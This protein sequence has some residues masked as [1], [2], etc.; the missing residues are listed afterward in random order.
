M[1]R[2]VVGLML[3]A[4]PLAVRGENAGA[5]VLVN[6][7]APD[8]ADFHTLLEP[9]LVHFGVP[10]ETLDLAEHRLDNRLADSSLV[11][12]GHCGLDPARRFLNEAA[13]QVLADAVRRGTGLVSFDGLVATWT[14]RQAQPV[15]RFSQEIFGWRFTPAQE[16]GAI[17]IAGGHWITA[18]R[19][20]PRRLQLKATMLVPGLAPGADE[21]QVLAGAAGKPLL[22]AAPFGSGRAV[23]FS[24]YDW[25]QPAVKGKL[26]GLD[27]LVWRSLVWAARKP[28]VM[29]GMPRYLVMRV[30]DVSGFGIESNRHLGW[31]ETVNRHGLKPWLGVFIDDMREDAE[32]T[33]R[34][35][36]FTREEL[37][38]ASPHARRWSSFFYLD[39][40][41][42]ND[43]RQRNVTGR[44]WPDEKMAANFAEAGQFF[45]ANGIVMGKVV[46][47]HFYEFARNNFEGLERWGIGLVGTVLRPGDGYGAMVPAAGPYLSGEPPRP[48]D[49]KD[50]IYIADWLK[51]PGRPEFDRRF[52]N[53]VLEIRD[54]AGYEW[55]PSG[56]PVAEAIRRG[57]EECRRAYDSLL[58]AVLF[59][60][61]SD[62]IQ[63]ISPRDWEAII[64]GVMA[65]LAPERPVPVT[66]DFL[67]RYMRVLRTSRIEAARDGT[68]EFT[69]AADIPAKFCV[70]EQ[71]ETAREVEVPA[72]QG[73]T[74]VAWR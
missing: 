56:V 63:H 67:C 33:R 35:A 30:D 34:L 8:F 21:A 22:V 52:F 27:D 60:H 9:Y 38:T 61:E 45:R 57:I 74:R 46:L 5:I 68:V 16:A 32:A 53:F 15:Y 62:H 65:G 37:V 39:E 59:T 11:I 40:P 26:Y 25:V 10:Y 55:A 23:Q 17:E 47:P 12:I 14:R 4:L 50:P 54:V 13:E 64:S 29:R 42:R 70:W 48:S 44:P 51:V 1:R 6:S 36:G 66:Y 58:P 69:G 18:Q 19:P 31:V 72:F 71:R 2:L 20:A 43:D 28:F 73:R 49:A 7:E 24:T 3:L 41:L